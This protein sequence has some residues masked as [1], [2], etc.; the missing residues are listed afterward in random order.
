MSFP[1]SSR[2]NGLL[3]VGVPNTGTDLPDEAA[4]K[5]SAQ[6]LAIANADWRIHR[7]CLHAGLLSDSTSMRTAVHHHAIDVNR[8]PS[9]MSPR[10]GQNTTALCALTDFNGDPICKTAVEPDAK[11]IK[12]R[13]A[14]H[15]AYCHAE[16]SEEIDRI[17]AVHDFA[18]LYDCHSLRSKIPFLPEG[19]LPDKNSRDAG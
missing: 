12:D 8:D 9:G 14:I 5:L 11:A 13:R 1:E 10:S 4:E 7:H 19:A 6:G 16:L 17:R 3:V 18:T 15:H 2:G